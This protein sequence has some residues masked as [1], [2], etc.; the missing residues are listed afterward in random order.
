MKDLISAT[1]H[2]FIQYKRQLIINNIDKCYD[3]IGDPDLAAENRTEAIMWPA[4]SGSL[5]TFNEHK[6][7][8]YN[9]SS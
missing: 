3:I 6:K 9:C 5:V 4:R 8:L 2:D 7:S 1:V